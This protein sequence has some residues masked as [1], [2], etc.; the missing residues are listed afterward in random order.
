MV[1]A[2][3]RYV[4]IFLNLWDRQ[5][6]TVLHKQI[7]L[8]KTNVMMVPTNKRHTKHGVTQKI[9]VNSENSF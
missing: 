3:D 4:S 5:P 7:V 2:M 9:V 1:R 8:P 6:K